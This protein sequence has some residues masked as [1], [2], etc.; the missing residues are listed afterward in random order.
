MKKNFKAISTVLFAAALVL[1]FASTTA[2][3]ATQTTASAKTAFVDFTDGSWAS[4]TGDAMPAGWTATDATIT[5]PGAYS[6]GLDFSGTESGSVEGVNFCALVVANGNV[7]FPGY[8]LRID[9][10]K[11]NG[12]SVDITKN[13]TSSD[14]KIEMRSNIW[15]QWVSTLPDD[16]RCV[17]GDITDASPEIVDSSLFTGVQSITVDFTVLD[18]DGNDGSAAVADDTATTDDTAATDT[19]AADDTAAT[20]TDVPKTG[21]VGLGLVYGLGAIATG[22]AVLKRKER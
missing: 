19:T 13:Y 10:I 5:G 9:D 7:D 4:N 14:D 6:V 17:D 8:F 3:A 2:S 16:A 21:V 12:E 20:T 22:A 11:I 18:A 1:N 15:N